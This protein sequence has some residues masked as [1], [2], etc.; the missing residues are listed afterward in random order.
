MT[1]APGPTHNP[2][3]SVKGLKSAAA[4]ADPVAPPRAAGGAGLRVGPDS[5]LPTATATARPQRPGAIEPPARDELERV[6]AGEPEALGAFFERYFD[7]V[8]GLVYRLLGERSLAEDVTQEVFLKVHRAVHRLDVTRDPAPWL[9]AIAY[10]ACRD[11]WRS[12]NYRVGRRSA[13]LDDPAIGVQL[14]SRAADP[15]R[16]LLAAERER[17]VQEAIS[18]LPEPL[19]TAVVLYDYQGLSHQEVARLTGIN[20]AAARKRYSR[21]LASLGSMLKESLG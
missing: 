19:R 13:T 11:L 3:D 1:S 8:F 6:R 4:G 2:P 21:A 16:Q 12:S 15:E 5:D 14:A 9:T 18:R 20:H 7:H 10:N 17:L